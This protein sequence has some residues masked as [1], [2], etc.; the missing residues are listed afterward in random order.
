[1]HQLRDSPGDLREF[2]KIIK[3]YEPLKSQPINES[4]RYIF[5]E[6]H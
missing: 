2:E 5:I 4:I 1:M 3:K 6:L